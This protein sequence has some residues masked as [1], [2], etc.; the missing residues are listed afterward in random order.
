MGFHSRIGKT[1]RIAY[2]MTD[3]AALPIALSELVRELKS[4]RLLD[5]TVTSGHAF[6]GDLE[7][8]SIPSALL[9]A[10]HGLKPDM[11]IV[12]LG[13]GIVGTG[14]SLGFSG[15][16]Q[17]WIIDL[18]AKLNGKPVVVPRVSNADQRERHFG[19]SHHSMTILDFANHSAFL[20]ISSLIPQSFT[21]FMI[22]KIIQNGLLERHQWLMIDDLPAEELF[23]KYQ[24]KV[25]TMGRN[26]KEDPYFFQST[27]SAGVLAAMV[28]L[29]QMSSLKRI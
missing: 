27:V 12:A 28:A 23:A 29:D 25:K 22:Q 17:S 19:I 3:G 18:V 14:T 13:P 16:E 10:Y 20:G 5:L 6:G 26:I 9:A 7:A 11:I 4:K 2:I 15:I 24:M 1:P 8:V 21:A